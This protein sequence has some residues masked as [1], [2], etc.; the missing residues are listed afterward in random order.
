MPLSDVPYREV[1]IEGVRESEILYS[2]FFILL[3]P[4]GALPRGQPGHQAPG[5]DPYRHSQCAGPRPRLRHGGVLPVSQGESGSE[6]VM[7]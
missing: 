3:A 5:G 2:S 4:E 7:M 6:G 1:T